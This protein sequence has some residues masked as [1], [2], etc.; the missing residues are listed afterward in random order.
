MHDCPHDTLPK[1]NYKKMLGH[2]DTIAEFLLYI[3]YKVKSNNLIFKNLFL[4]YSSAMLAFD[5]KVQIRFPLVNQVL[6][7]H[8]MKMFVFS[9]YKQCNA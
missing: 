8:W 2:C 1:Q 7:V 9:L 3:A 4:L 5:N 6:S